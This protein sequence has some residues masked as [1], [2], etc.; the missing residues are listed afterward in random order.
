MNADTSDSNRKEDVQIPQ[1]DM[2]DSYQDIDSSNTR[3]KKGFRATSTIAL[4]FSIFAIAAAGYSLYLTTA[5]DQT[6]T[7][8]AVNRFDALESQFE[9]LRLSQLEAATLDGEIRGQLL[10]RYTELEKTIQDLDKTYTSDVLRLEQKQ[11]DIE[12]NLGRELEVLLELI[13]STR[14][15]LDQDTKDWALV[16][17]LQVLQLANER[18]IL[19]GDVELAVQAMQL[20]QKR[21]A[22]L[23]DPE[24]LIVRR[25][26][27]EVIALLSQIVA[28][29][30][31]GIVLQLT[32]LINRVDELPLA[33]DVSFALIDDASNEALG[34][35]VDNSDQSLNSTLRHLGSSIAADLFSLVRMRDITKTQLPK[36]TED[37]QFLVYESLRSPLNAAQL[38]LLRGLSKSYKDSLKRADTAL[39]QSFDGSTAEVK[40]FR[41]EIKKLSGIQLVDSYPDVSKALGLLQNIT[42]E[43]RDVK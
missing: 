29:D 2:L 28:P 43:R 27:A 12:G 35:T 30:V 8:L 10:D 41:A 36:L 16:E 23:A 37:Q 15:L 14:R 20:A 9:T 17:I 13:E 22:E 40:L 18:L 5:K 1:K 7:I 4:V 19:V 39:I 24:L 42:K 6:E 26:L 33:T 11:I 21:L 31:D 32:S 3:K 34:V 38:S 25:Q